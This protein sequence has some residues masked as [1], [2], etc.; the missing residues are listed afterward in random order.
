MLALTNKNDNPDR[1]NY[2]KVGKNSQNSS[3]FL[4]EGVLSIDS[5][6]EKNCTVG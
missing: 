5:S 3:F 1:G 6:E 4:V 2:I